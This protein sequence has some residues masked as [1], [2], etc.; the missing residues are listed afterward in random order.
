ML[1]LEGLAVARVDL[2]DA[3]ARI[4]HVVTA[5]S[6]AAVC[7]S[8]GMTSMSVKQN[9]VTRP[10]DLPYGPAAVKLVWHKRRWRCRNV[11]CPRQSFTEQ[12]AAVPPRARTTA[13]L[14]QAVAEAVGDNR[15]VAEVARTHRV[16]WPT[17]Q[18]AVSS[19]CGQVLGEPAPTRWL[20]IDETRF[21]RPRWHRDGDGRWQL[22]EPWETGFVDLTGVQGLLGQVDGRTSGAV[23]AWLAARSPAWR[24]AVQVVAIDPSAP[25]AAAVRQLLPQARIA[26]DHFHLVAAANRVVTQV[27]Q[28]VTREHLGRRGRRT[29]PLWV[30]R[31]HLL[32]ARERLSDKR[33]ATMWNACI[34]TD[35]S[36][37]LLAT[38]IA[39]EHLR[40][41]LA[42][43]AA[44]AERHI[45]RA[46]L[47]DFYSWCATTS[48]PEVH[49]L[50]ELIEQWWPA[51][52]TFLE[53]GVTNAA[54]EGTNRLIKQVKRQAC[55]FRNR[56]NYRNR[57]RFHCTRSRER[58]R[59]GSLPA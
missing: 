47:F 56:T 6:A 21:G 3:G 55:G 42:C 4:V 41:L 17:V 50:A 51:V 13:R 9:A 53:T 29:D 16:S 39:K 58:A 26:V 23:A 59:K 35:P 52:L 10:K 8:C 57:V 1:G 15:C 54:T 48:V 31:R 36:G 27:R 14:R 28:R 7:P 34:D 30:N 33:F 20:G 45:I 46:R 22:V 40:D 11:E 19:V 37:D 44:R 38:W 18:R 43:A 25:Y 32:R 12:V 5:D 2:D 24:Q 49:A